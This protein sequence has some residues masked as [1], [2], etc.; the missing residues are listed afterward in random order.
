MNR[1]I[2]LGLCLLSAPAWAQQSNGTCIQQWQMGPWT[3]IDAQ[4]AMVEAGRK[5]YVVTVPDC[6]SFFTGRN[7]EVVGSAGSRV[8]EGAAILYYEGSQV[9]ETCIITDIVRI[10][11][12]AQ[13]NTVEVN[14]FDE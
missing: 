7:N 3:Q 4:T 13:T 6:E 5:Q 14:E 12:N 10:R 11:L 2:L 8:C 9:I 1:L